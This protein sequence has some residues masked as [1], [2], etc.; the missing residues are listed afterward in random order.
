MDTNQIAT[1]LQPFVTLDEKRLAQTLTYVNLIDKWNA[2]INL[3]AV[4]QPEYI[5]T[6][7]FGESFFVARCL[8]P[9]GEIASAI[10]L[11]SG[12]GFPGLPLAMLAPHLPTT[13][14]ES[15]SK[16]AAFLN[17]VIR[18]LGLENVTVFRGRGEDYAGKA[19]IVTMRAV[20]KF[21]MAVGLAARLLEPA[22]RLA[23]MIGTGQIEKARELGPQLT[24]SDPVELPG[25]HSRVL[26]IGAIKNS[27]REP[28]P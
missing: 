17:E 2:R 6:R 15:N 11:G 25:G 12:A 7:H 8:L 18:T 13:L 22:G 24:W 3:T 19:N 28:D 26:L 14:I 16:K 1:L 27:V 9:L 23:L 10:D 21:N 5:V 20:E 4:R